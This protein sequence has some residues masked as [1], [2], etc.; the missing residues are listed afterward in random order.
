MWPRSLLRTWLGRRQ[1]PIQTRK[2][3]RAGKS[4][5]PKLEILEER[6]APAVAL[7]YVA[8][9]FSGPPTITTGSL[10]I[11]AANSASNLNV[12]HGTNGWQFQLTGDTFGT[13]PTGF[14]Q[15]TTGSTYTVTTTKPMDNLYIG[16]PGTSASSVV[17]NTADTVNLG[18]FSLGDPSLIKVT[19]NLIVN[20]GTIKFSGAVTAINLVSLTSV[21]SLTLPQ[22]GVPYLGSVTVNAGPPSG[23]PFAGDPYVTGPDWGSYGYAVNDKITLNNTNTKTAAGPYTV[24]AIVGDNMYLSSGSLTTALGTDLSK[25]LTN[26][27]VK[28][29]GFTPDIT[30]TI[31]ELTVTGAGSII[32]GALGG[33]SAESNNG[34]SLLE[35]IASTNNGNITLQDLP[36]TNTS[37]FLG[38]VNA[39]SG[40]IQLAVNGSIASAFSPTSSN[41]NLTASAVNLTTSGS[42]S[43]I[44][45][46]YTAGVF[47][48]APIT[49][50]SGVPGQSLE[51]TAATNDGLVNIQDSSPVGLTIKSV[52]ANQAGQAPLVSNGQVV[53]NSTPSAAAGPTYISGSNDV[54]INS[55][56]PIVLNSVSATG[57]V[58]ITGQ[59][60]LEGNEQSPNVIA[61]SVDLV[62]T[63]TADF[64]GQ[65]TFAQSPTGDTLT[66][67][68]STWGNLTFA[69]GDSIVISGAIARADNGVFT[70]KSVS[71]NTLILTQSFVLTPLTQAVT[72]GDG[73]I[74]LTS[75]HF[76]VGGSPLFCQR[77][78]GDI[79]LNAGNAVNSTAVNVSAGTVGA[80]T[81]DDASVM[82]NA[83]FLSIGE[84]FA[85]GEAAVAANSG[86]LLEFNLG[87]VTRGSIFYAGG[88]IYGHDVSLTS[89]YNIGTASSPFLTGARFGLTVDATATSPSSANINILNSFRTDSLNTVGVS[90]YDGNVLIRENSYG[91]IVGTQTFN[92]GVLSETKYGSFYPNVLMSFANTDDNNGSAGDVI[93]SGT[94]Y[95]SAIAA[96][97]GANGTAGAGQI[98]TKTGGV[99]NGNN[100]T[101][102]LSAG[103]GVGTSGSSVNIT[104]VATLDASTN[105]GVINVTGPNTPSNPLTLS[106]ST[107]TG[108]IYVTW[109]GDIDLSSETS[110]TAGNVLDSISAP[111]TVTLDAVGGAIVDKF[112]STVSAST[113]VLT[114]TK[115]I[116]TASSPLETTSRGTMN[117]TAIATGGG[118]FLD[119]ST[120]LTVDQAT[121]GKGNPLAISATGNLILLGQIA[122][123]KGNV[124]LTATVGAFA[125]GN[126]TTSAA[127]IAT[128]QQTVIPT[129]MEPYITVGAKLLIDAGQTNQ[130]QVSVNAV[131]PTTFTATSRMPMRPISPSLRPTSLSRPRPPSRLGSR[132]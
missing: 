121:V 22:T 77:T 24:E 68:G 128:G 14:T 39:G 26:I 83:N 58:T 11:A 54:T 94:V 1:A 13:L 116:G 62:A 117:L 48:S 75:S 63:G 106:A 59:Y 79:Y 119:S 130:E 111:G 36:P 38:S 69:A 71:G 70:I 2:K 28:C 122:D 73:M 6:L 91:N 27:S 18:P 44:G 80:V 33:S 104:N 49:T 10:Y 7:S 8:Q 64:K 37:V 4:F 99:I 126:V 19:G 53:Y 120:A 103:T 108:D 86:A 43:A 113:L 67:T 9:S 30:S 81:T 93:V 127:A 52:T 66:N 89:P 20:A 102:M 45:G 32:S 51:L 96:G 3:I 123:P 100:S 107:S 56:G 29:S 115:G 12:S 65:V 5:K 84:I 50:Q 35:L 42:Q 85:T 78:H 109:N 47:A 101:V 40:T 118:L 23:Q 82:S 16:G 74:G 25:T 131:T 31:A 129:L 90:T 55:P 95:V 114:A 112:N 57:N 61:Q 97:I 125:T 21:S 124:T 132:R 92:N 88:D 98:L 87:G 41:V 72:V 17:T 15:K 60:I 105:A 34:G 110:S 46:Y 76:F